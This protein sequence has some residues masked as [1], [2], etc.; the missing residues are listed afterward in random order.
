MAPSSGRGGNYPVQQIGGNYVGGSLQGGDRGFAA[1]QFS[2]WRRPVGGS[3]DPIEGEETYYTDGSCNKQSG[4]SLVSQ[5]I[6]QVLFLEKI[7]PAQEGGSGGPGQKARLM[8][9]ALKE[10]LAPVPIP[11]AA[12]QQRGPRKPIGGSNQGQYMNTPWRNPAEEREKLGGSM[13]KC[14]DRQAGFLGLGPW[15]K[16]P[17]NFPMAQVHQGLMGGSLTALGMSLNFPIAKVE[18]VKVGG[19]YGQMPRQTGGF[20]RPWSMGKEAPQPHGSSASG[21]D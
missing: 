15:G 1:P 8:A 16:K 13:A 7:E 12:A 20:F 5:G 9:E 2:L 6:R 3:K 4:G 11:F 10:A 14:P 19:S 18:P 21:A 17:R